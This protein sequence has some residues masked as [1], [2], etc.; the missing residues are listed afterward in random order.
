MASRNFQ[1][2]VNRCAR[3]QNLIALFIGRIYF[4]YDLFLLVLYFLKLHF[5]NELIFHLSCRSVVTFSMALEA[6]VELFWK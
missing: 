6:S 4:G 2:G 5:S 3:G 1:S